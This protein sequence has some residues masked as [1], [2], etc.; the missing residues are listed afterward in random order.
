MTNISQIFEQAVSFIQ[1]KDP[2]SLNLLIQ[3]N[4]QLL[5][6]SDSDASNQTLIHHTLSYAS[7]AGDDPS[8]WSTPECADVLWK[9]GALID[10]KFFL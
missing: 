1:Q 6:Y 5:Q 4:P 10:T 7:F 3:K 8:L 9:N 2:K